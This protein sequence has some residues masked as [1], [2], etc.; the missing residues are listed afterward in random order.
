[1]KD[2]IYRG[3]SES[4]EITAAAQQEAW[5]GRSAGAIRRTQDSTQR[6]KIGLAAVLFGGMMM[7]AGAAMVA[8]A[9]L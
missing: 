6:R 3:R 2:Q 1:M 4:D 9:A 7:V 5:V 8:A